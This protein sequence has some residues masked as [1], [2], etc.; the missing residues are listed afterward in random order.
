[1]A[2]P[3]HRCRP[4]TSSVRMYPGRLQDYQTQR[5]VPI[6]YPPGGVDDSVRSSALGDLPGLRLPKKVFLSKSVAS[7]AG[8]LPASAARLTLCLKNKVPL[9]HATEGCSSEMAS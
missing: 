7:P 4:L 2:V 5:W 6:H 9:L 3:H 8:P 1:M